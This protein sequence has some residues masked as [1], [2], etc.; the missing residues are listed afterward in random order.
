MEKIIKTIALIG[1]SS[2][3]EKYGYKILR[4][5]INK[6]YTVYPVNPASK[7]IEGI[8][9]FSSIEELHDDV[10]LFV[11]VV[12]AQAGLDITKKLINRGLKKFWYQPGAESE[13][14]IGF[15][16]NKKVRFSTIN[17][18]MMNTIR[19]GDLTF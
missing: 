10:D 5:L 17:C 19:Q 12:P 15:L 3:K 4:D 13:E 9:V 6:G 1:A 8:K 16:K 14:I 18:I 11:F 7:E 2:R